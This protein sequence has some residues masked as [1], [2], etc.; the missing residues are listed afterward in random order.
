MLEVEE[1]AKLKAINDKDGEEVD[2]KD[3]DLHKSNDED[4]E[5]VSLDNE[6]SQWH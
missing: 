5:G 1:E 3:R 4:K 2:E 6:H